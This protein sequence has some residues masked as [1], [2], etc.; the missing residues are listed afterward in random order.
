MPL[1]FT[2]K[3][4]SPSA[5]SFDGQYKAFHPLNFNSLNQ[6][7]KSPN[8][9]ELE[10]NRPLGKQFLSNLLPVPPCFHTTKRQSNDSRIMLRNRPLVP[11]VDPSTRSKH[12]S[13]VGVSKGICLHLSDTSDLKKSESFSVLPKIMSTKK[14]LPSLESEKQTNPP[15]RTTL[16]KPG[17]NQLASQH[18]ASR[19][20]PNS[21]LFS[22]MEVQ[23]SLSKQPKDS[24]EQ[25]NAVDCNRPHA[26][27][28]MMTEDKRA[29]D[30]W[31][32]ACSSVVNENELSGGL[33]KNGS[34]LKAI[35]SKK[36][37]DRLTTSPSWFARILCLKHYT[38]TTCSFD[39]LPYSSVQI[40]RFDF[41]L[42][43]PDAVVLQHQKK[44][45]LSQSYR[46]SFYL[47]L[48]TT[49]QMNYGFLIFIK[50]FSMI[51]VIQI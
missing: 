50:C 27:F 18:L 21:K 47:A 14:P 43:S 31:G 4:E 17:L 33:K 29:L 19:S 1:Q 6:Y 26:L 40:Q 37:R 46:K 39:G 28:H 34:N 10:A 7:Q 3:C 44:A 51:F 24:D 11:L 36:V 5:I 23:R 13:T 30:T 32:S 8:K 9:S 49:L 42:P 41:T 20:A 16:Q 45:F 12:D 35:F 25:K 15:A 22:F 2:D 38:W 48:T